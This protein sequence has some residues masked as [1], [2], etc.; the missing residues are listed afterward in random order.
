MADE[1]GVTRYSTVPAE[2][3]PGLVNIW[4]MVAPE[5]ALAPV[6]PPVMA[7]IVHEK[8]QGTDAVNAIFGPVPLQVVEVVEFVTTGIGLTVTVTEK[9]AHDKPVAISVGVTR[10]STVPAA[11][12]LGLVSVWLIVDPEPELAPVIAPVIVPTVQVNVLEGEATR[13]IF[14]PEP[15]HIV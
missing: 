7:P 10:Y 5:L 3:L 13:L 1:V 14:E 11:E 9:E 8:L 4:L 2:E 12:L 6:I 15:L